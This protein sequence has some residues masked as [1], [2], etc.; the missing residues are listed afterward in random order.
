[1]IEQRPY[2][3]ISRQRLWG[4]PLPIFVDKKTDEP[5]RDA[6]VIERV[7]AAFE[8][9]GGDAWFASDPQRFLGDDHKADD[10]EQ[11]FDVVEV[12]FYSGSTHAFVLEARPELKCP[13]DLSLAGPAP[14]RG[15]FHSSLLL[16]A[17][18]PPP[19]PPTP[20][21]RHPA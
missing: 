13:G 6:R 15:W 7:A 4:V 12:W 19:P 16:S 9:E 18:T 20:P 8:A 21:P 3:C 11:V 2:W 17:A 1:M 5:L 10:F 14:P